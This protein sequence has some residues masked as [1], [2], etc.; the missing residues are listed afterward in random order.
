MFFYYWVPVK[1]H[2]DFKKDGIVLKEEIRRP[3]SDIN[4]NSVEIT[5]KFDKKTFN[6]K[7]NLLIDNVHK[8]YFLEKVQ[9]DTNGFIIYKCDSVNLDDKQDIELLNIQV[10][11]CFKE[12]FH[13]HEYHDSLSDALIT[14]YSSPTQADNMKEVLKHYYQLYTDKFDA[15]KNLIELQNIRNILIDF[16]N[17]V[18]IVKAS[19]LIKEAKRIILSARGEMVYADF[20]LSSALHDDKLFDLYQE[21]KVHFEM[22][23]K[24]LDIY[25]D[26]YDNLYTQID[27]AYSHNINRFQMILAFVGI[28]LG[29]IGVL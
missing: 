6:I 1:K 3:I 20:L 8:E 13:N 16:E 7:V 21:Y 14:A 2:I 15:F 18:D 11:H 4:K 29:I 27:L 5:L 17:S 23:E 9:Y 24:E 25:Y 26:K 12:F 22:Y 28:C 10:Y 19:I